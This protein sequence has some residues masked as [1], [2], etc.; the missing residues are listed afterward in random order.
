M[1]KQQKQE[2]A[3]SKTHKLA[4]GELEILE[5][6]WREGPVTLPRT[7]EWFQQRGRHLASTTL[8]TRLNRLVEK[9][10]VARIAENPAQYEA[11]IPRE[12]VSGRHLELLKELCGLNWLPLFAQ[13]AESRDFSAEEIEY[14]EQIIQ[15]NR[16]KKEK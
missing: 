14:L 11:A 8:H 13:L 4:P 16:R 7:R 6:L 2:D 10:I 12:N 15:K 5:L 1:S 3:A 9:G